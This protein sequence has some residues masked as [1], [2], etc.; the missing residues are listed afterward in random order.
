M[1]LIVVVVVVVL[2]VIVVV[3]TPNIT[4]R[5][6]RPSFTCGLIEKSCTQESENFTASWGIGIWA[7]ELFFTKTF[8]VLFS[9]IFSKL[10]WKL[11]FVVDRLSSLPSPNHRDKIWNCPGSHPERKHGEHCV[12]ERQSHHSAVGSVFRS[13]RGKCLSVVSVSMLFADRS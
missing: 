13:H 7:Q 4:K 9:F 5:S 12:H 2:I 3:V 6:K 8:S 10:W 11:E 1:S